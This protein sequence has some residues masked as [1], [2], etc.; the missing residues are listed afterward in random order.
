MA[1]IEIDQQSGLAVDAGDISWLQLGE[2]NGQTYLDIT[3]KS[4]ERH[5]VPHW[6][7]MGGV[8]VY[9]LRRQLL[10]EGGSQQ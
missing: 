1:L 8:D 5:R 10:A 7:Y 2:A 4:G 9:A 3:M 6:P